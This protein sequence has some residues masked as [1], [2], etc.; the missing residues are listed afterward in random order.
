VGIEAV[1]FTVYANFSTGCPDKGYPVL[2][3][4]TILPSM[5]ARVYLISSKGTSINRFIVFLDN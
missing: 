3:Y 2:T 1:Q 4:D 5:G